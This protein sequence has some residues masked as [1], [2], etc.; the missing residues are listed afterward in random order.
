MDPWVKVY[1]PI[2]GPCGIAG[3]KICACG[4]AS[5]SEKIGARPVRATL[6]ERA[7]REDNNAELNGICPYRVERIK[8]GPIF[9]APRR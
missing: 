1:Y 3:G 4:Q 2:L 5:P 9:S 7:P 6:G 8:T